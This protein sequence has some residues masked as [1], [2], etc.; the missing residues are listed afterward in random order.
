MV[1]LFMALRGLAGRGVAR[2]RVSVPRGAAAN[3]TRCPSSPGPRGDHD[4]GGGTAASLARESRHAQRV[5]LWRLGPSRA[6]PAPGCSPQGR[7]RFDLPGQS[8]QAAAHLQKGLL[9][10]RRPSVH[11]L[12]L[13]TCLLASA[14]WRG[15]GGWVG[16]WVG[17]EGAGAGGA[18]WRAVWT[19]GGSGGA[20]PHVL[21]PAGFSPRTSPLRRGGIPRP[22]AARAAASQGH[23]LPATPH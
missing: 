22:A 19:L 14:T 23:C 15:M 8:D 12:P 5:P 13:Q 17:E 11:S 3:G 16:G 21:P 4:A 9:L 1:P 2:Q 18:G 20:L 10:K 7:A 6:V